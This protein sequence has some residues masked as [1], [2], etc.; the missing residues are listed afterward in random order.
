MIDIT[1][2]EAINGFIVSVFDW[3]EGKGYKEICE[4][5]IDALQIV[6]NYVKKECEKEVKLIKEGGI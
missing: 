3:K 4:R 5:K 1:I 6:L 2:N